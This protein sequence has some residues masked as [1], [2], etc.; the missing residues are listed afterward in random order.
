MLQ[1]QFL[2][3]TGGDVISVLSVGSAQ[4][5]TTKGVSTE[6]KEGFGTAGMFLIHTGTLSNLTRE[7]SYDNV[8]YYTP[9]D[10]SN[11]SLSKCIT[12]SSNNSRFISLDVVGSGYIVTPYTRYNATTVSGG[13]LSMVY[14]SDEV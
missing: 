10:V 3:N 2:M 11:A 4:T 6:R 8:T 1:V 5:I 7:V 14:V 9:Y 12:T 13:T